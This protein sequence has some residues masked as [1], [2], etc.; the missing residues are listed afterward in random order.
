MSESKFL[1]FANEVTNQIISELEKGNVIWKQPWKNLGL[2][3]NLITNNSY[4]GFN[5]FYLNWKMQERSFKSPYFMTFQQ[6]KSIGAKIKKGAKSIQ[7]VFWK[8]FS[9]EKVDEIEIA[10]NVRIYPFVHY[11]FNIDEIENVDPI[12][13]RNIAT[14][15]KEISTFENCEKLIS[16]MQNIPEI[17]FGGDKAYYAP[18]Q[19]YIQIPIIKQFD[20]AENYYSTLFH[21]II[22]S[23]GHK[24]RLDR[25]SENTLPTMFGSE[26][27]SKEELV[28][29]IGATFLNAHCGIK[30]QVFDT[31][32][33]YIKG[34]LKT[35]KSD[36]KMIFSASTKAQKAYTFLVQ[37]EFVEE[38]A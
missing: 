29:E 25:F 15:Q 1:Q 18:T 7:I 8:K 31:S 17:K 19:D 21:E 4:T 37:H 12:Y 32:V 35:L 11:V 9:N 2:C 16:E 33:A 36:P 22:H 34:W 23:T 6:A 5:Q 3:K 30:E 38:M 14:E 10:N 24:S 13:L 26:D 20:S 28:A 27:Y